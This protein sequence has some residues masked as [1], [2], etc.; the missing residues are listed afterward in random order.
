ML[1]ALFVVMAVVIT[2]ALDFND[3][4]KRQDEMELDDAINVFSQHVADKR[5]RRFAGNI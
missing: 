1:I 4:E 2:T 3:F 5:G